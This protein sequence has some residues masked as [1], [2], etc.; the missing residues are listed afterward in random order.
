MD[1]DGQPMYVL[2]GTFRES[3]MSGDAVK[4]IAS[5]SGHSTIAV[6]QRDGFVYAAEFEVE[7]TEKSNP[8][9]TLVLMRGVQF[10]NVTFGIEVP[11]NVYVY[12]PKPNVRVREFQAEPKKGPDLNLG[13]LLP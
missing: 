13:P 7:L 6:G 10:T 11:D 8:A 4:E 9:H 1:W 3:A 12:K 5:A 2:N